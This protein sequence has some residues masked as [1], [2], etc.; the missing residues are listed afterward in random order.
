VGVGVNEPALHHAARHG[1]VHQ[2]GAA[3]AIA[4]GVATAGGRQRVGAGVLTGRTVA[5]ATAAISRTRNK[6]R[7]AE[8]GRMK[9]LRPFMA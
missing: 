8:R 4:V 1:S 6:R 2:P 9:L 3:G 7:K 5:L